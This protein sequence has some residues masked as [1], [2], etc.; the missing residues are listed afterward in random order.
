M[1]D[2]KENIKRDRM[3][4]VM[5]QTPGSDVCVCVH[6]QV[7]MHALAYICVCVFVIVFQNRRLMIHADCYFY[8]K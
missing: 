2:Q 5:N 3:I 7:C 8:G 1:E 4:M 6:M